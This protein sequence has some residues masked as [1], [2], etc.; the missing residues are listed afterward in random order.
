MTA[1]ALDPVIHAPA[2]LRIVATLAAL[3]QGDALRLTR[4]QRMLHVTPGH[5]TGDL[6]ELED[7]G[8]LACASTG[9][10]GAQAAVALTR[11]GRDGL[12]RYTAML[13]HLLAVPATQYRMA[14]A[15]EIRVGDADRDAAAAALSQHFAHGRLT[16]DELNARLEIAL[17][18]TTHGALSEATADLPEVTVVSARVSFSRGTRRP[19]HLPGRHRHPHRGRS[20]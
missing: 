5:L 10:G 2:R 1:D 15:P 3:P 9:D 17:A 14:P 8:Y 19:G 12:D 4:L 16:L 18:A 11:Q 6:H 7:A 13:R 20:S